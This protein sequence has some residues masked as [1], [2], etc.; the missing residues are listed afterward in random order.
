MRGENY[1][2]GGTPLIDIFYKH[3]NNSDDPVKEAGKDCGWL[4]K[5]VINDDK[6]N[7]EA[8]KENMIRKYRWVKD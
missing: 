3:E 5:K 8:K 4:L 2:W 1:H 7:F 6:R